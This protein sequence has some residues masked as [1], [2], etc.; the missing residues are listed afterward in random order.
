MFSFLA[1]EKKY[2]FSATNC[3]LTAFTI[4]DYKGISIKAKVSSV[5]FHRKM[6]KAPPQTRSKEQK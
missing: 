5:K 1:V 2:K 4:L 6:A 3:V